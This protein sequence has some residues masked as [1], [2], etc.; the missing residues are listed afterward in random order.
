MP[1][2]GRLGAG[3]RVRSRGRAAGGVCA[4]GCLRERRSDVGNWSGGRGR[5]HF[6]G[7]QGDI[8]GSHQG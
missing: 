8:W 1:G 3:L 6:L 7:G 2:A 4:G 5:V